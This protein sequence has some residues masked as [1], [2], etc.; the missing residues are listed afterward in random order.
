MFC[1]QCGKAIPDE[2]QFCGNC[3]TALATLDPATGEPPIPLAQQLPFLSR[4]DRIAAQPWVRYWARVFDICIM[5]LFLVLTLGVAAA[6]FDFDLDGLL[7]TA[8][9]GQGILILSWMPVEAV[10]MSTLGTTPGKWLCRIRV[11]PLFGDKPDFEAAFVRSAKVWF[12]GLGLGLPIISIVAQ[13]VAYNKLKNTG[14]TSW[15][16]EGN[17]TIEHGEIGPFRLLLIASL[18]VA[19]LALTLF[20]QLQK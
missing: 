4:A 6:I 14:Q 8:G 12:R 3:G 11:V 17:F 19:Y 13:I 16:A 18:V 15:D 1:A 5:G 10:L 2:T 9:R 20:G 7:A